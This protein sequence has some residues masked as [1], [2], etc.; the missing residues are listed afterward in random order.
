M[1]GSLVSPMPDSFRNTG[2]A[3][4]LVGQT[5]G[6]TPWS[7]RDA[8]VTLPEQRYRHPAKRAQAD[9]GVGLSPG[10]LPHDQC[11]RVV[12]RKLCGIRLY[13][14]PTRSYIASTAASPAA[15]SGSA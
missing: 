7:A 5:P 13:S 11:R 1:W 3:A 4:E 6:Q 12:V 9:G 14:P 8:L 15:L 10:V 2:Y